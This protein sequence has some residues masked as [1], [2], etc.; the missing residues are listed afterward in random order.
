MNAWIL[1]AV[2]VQALV[3]RADRKLGAG[4]GFLVT[5]GIL[6]WGVGVYQQGAQ[7]LFFGIPL[8]QSTF[9]TLCLAWFI[10]DVKV[11]KAACAAAETPAETSADDAAIDVPALPATAA[12]CEPVDSAKQGRCPNCD[13]AL[14]LDAPTCPQCKAQF[15]L[16]AAWKVQPVQ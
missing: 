13:T 8:P 1:A 2:F 14:A 5:G 16:N 11:W 4:L 9:V 3:S 15:G 7:I 12:A 10:Y 6:L